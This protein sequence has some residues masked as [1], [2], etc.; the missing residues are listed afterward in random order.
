MLHLAAAHDAKRVAELLL[1][2]GVSAH[3]FDNYGQRAAD[4]VDNAT[5]RLIR[6]WKGSKKVRKEA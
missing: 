1:Q 6:A 5:R 4:G 2:H 3:A